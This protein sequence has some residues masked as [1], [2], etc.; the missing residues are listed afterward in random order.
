MS[1]CVS[2]SEMLHQFLTERSVH[3]VIFTCLEQI[4]SFSSVLVLTTVPQSYKPLGIF[5]VRNCEIF[6]SL[7]LMK[8]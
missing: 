6:I 1:C 2:I 8:F 5:E 3:Y 4:H 7:K